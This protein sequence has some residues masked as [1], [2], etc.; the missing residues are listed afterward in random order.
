MS[1]SNTAGYL[2]RLVRYVWAEKPLI[3]LSISFGLLGLV[4]PFVYPMVIGSAIDVVILAHPHNGIV[5]TYDQRIHWLCVLTIAS[6]V[7]AVVWAVTGY[8]KGHFTLKL[9]NRIITRLRV[10]LFRHLQTLSL[11]FFA[12]QRTGGIIWRLIHEVHEVAHVIYAG[13][14]LVGFDFLQ[15]IAATILLA[16]ISW[17][18]ALAVL[19]LLPLYVLTFYFLNPRVRTSSEVVARHAGQISGNVQEQFTAISLI[20][21]YNAEARETA[22]FLHDNEQHLQH[23]LRQSHL[24]HLVGAVSEL[25]VHL[26][27]TV[28]IGY[29]CWLTMHDPRL[30]AGDLTKFL[31]YVG[32]MYG[33]LRRFA[34]LNLVYQNS[35]ASV[36][37]VFRVF[38]IRP[39]I[40]D[41]PDAIPT[42]PRDG[43]VIYENVRFRYG[44]AS[45]QSHVRLDEDASPDG[46][47]PW[48]LDGV[49]LHIRAGECVALIGPSGAGKTTIASLLPRLYEVNDGRILIDNVD[50]RDYQLA[51]LRSAIAI[52][53]QDAFLFSGSIRDNILYGRP[54]ATHAAVVA[55]A[56]AANAHGFIARMREGYDTLL[57]ERGI[58]LSG[59]QRQRISIARALLKDPRI[60]ILDE[61]TSA[62]DA[63]SESLVQ[64][65]LNRLMRGR[66]C[67]VIAHRLSTVRRADRILAI[68]NG[69]IV[70]T[71]CHDELVALDG[72]YAHLVRHQ[73][74]LQAPD[75]EAA[76]IG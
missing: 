6:A 7:T 10:D 48:I 45:D 30:T 42:P 49:N 14:L 47:G 43:D 11:E 32:I 23:V 51:A 75:G 40:V 64:Q 62:L 65:A 18:L 13:L 35:L 38:D 33:P 24:G 61:A 21:T 9:G 76:V 59:G 54:D 17:K 39:E 3:L 20:K 73:L 5:P 50:I 27:T 28:I 68:Q 58:G 29:G 19:I 34:D 16:L 2:P 56:K 53:Q 46:P 57:G 55:A 4:L 22:R 44:G 1:S 12:R 69:R 36:R 25:L 71:G 70:E 31:G 72:L 41:A 66:T 52:V 26:G 63:E 67:L 37:R 8:C 74:P 60:L 15:L